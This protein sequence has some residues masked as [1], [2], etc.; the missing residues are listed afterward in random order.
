MSMPSTMRAV[1]AEAGRLVTVQ[2]PVPS[3]AAGEA[4]V[5]VHA[6]AVNRADTLQRRGMYPVP[7]G[8]TDV[9]GLEMAGT[10]VSASGKWSAGDKVMALLSGGGYADYVTVPEDLLMR[11]PQGYDLA[12][13]AGLPETWLTAYQL[14]FLV[15]NA[16]EGESV[17][18]HAAGSG[19][20][21]AATQLATA[22]GLK[23]LATAGSPDKLEVARK[24]GAKGG[25]NYKEGPWAP[26]VKSATD[27]KGANVI[28]D[29]VGGSYWEQNV[30]AIAL[31]GRWVLYGLMGG[32][33]VEGPILA[34]LLRKRAAI[35]GTTLRSRSLEY[36]VA[37]TRRFA[38]HALNKFDQGEYD[39][40]LDARSFSLEDSQAAHE[41]MESNANIG[42]IIIRIAEG[43][44]SL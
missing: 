19:V 4:L 39:V 3:P 22:H 28:L 30:D 37:L 43:G 33:K 16:C 20:G 32:P 6:T 31:D 21:T 35:M 14:L 10:V 15:G 38:E 44:S 34:G 8:V 23:V 5:R 2:R 11:I 36:R 40:I 26:A 17:V 42:K 25:F 12:K 1:V 18:V 13:A 9:L 24:L 27:G 29:P 41:Y 7:P